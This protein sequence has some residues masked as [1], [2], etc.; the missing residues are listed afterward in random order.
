[1]IVGIANQSNAQILV[2]DMN[3]DG[4]LN[5]SDITATVSTILGSSSKS[6]IFGD[7]LV[8]EK[9]LY[10]DLGLPSGTLWATCNVGAT[11]PEE[12][13][14]H[15][16]WGETVPQENTEYDWSSYKYCNDS[17]TSLM[18]E[19]LTKYC[20]E[21][22]WG[23]EGF[24]DMLT[25]LEETDDA[26]FMN[27][28]EGWRT[29]TSAQMT[30]LYTECTW[31]W[32]SVNGVEGYLV[33]SKENLNYIFLPVTGM[34]SWGELLST[35]HGVYW[36]RS[37]YPGTPTDGSYLSFYQY[38]IDNATG[39]R[40]CLGMCVRPVRAS[41]GSVPSNK[42]VQSIT[43]NESSI[44]LGLEYQT[45]KQLTASISPS[46]AANPS[47][48]WG[49]SD[50]GVATM[51]NG[52]VTAVGEGTATITCTSLDG[53][54]ISA[55]CSVRVWGDHSGILDG[56]QYVDLALPSGTLWAAWNVGAEKPEDYG[57]FFAWGETE[58]QE[59]NAYSWTSYKFCKEVND[60]DEPSL[61]KYCV[62]TSHGFGGHTDGRTEL[63]PEDD[64]AYVNWG[65]DWRMPT[66]EQFEELHEGCTWDFTFLNGVRGYRAVSKNNGQSIFLPAAGCVSG[67]V[68]NDNHWGYYYSRTMYKDNE[69]YFRDLSASSLF[70]Y[71]AD[72]VSVDDYRIRYMG[73][74]IRP[75]RNSE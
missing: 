23:Y 13:G 46:D 68:R 27:W 66:R 60:R 7:N 5:V 54:N 35:D 9:H 57:D 32:T 41:T 67:G 1:M 19:T 22:F 50:T 15:Y 62:E 38:Q 45:T 2:G 34:Y 49:S 29:P 53:S 43:L 64:A 16:A 3:N 74:S 65:S 44:N 20:N 69:N 58:P 33:E 73:L 10:V 56:R 37:L 12:V 72:K 36:T 70:Y 55:L 61:T 4:E 14:N 8:I 48:V 31:T 6:Y 59:D 25:E 47:V 75:V 21:A 71:L 52:L 18:T 51:K 11:K 26:A 28:G 30:E 24:T 63:L 39:T 42:M 40:R 17:S